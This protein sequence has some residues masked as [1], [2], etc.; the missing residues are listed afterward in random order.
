LQFSL[1]LNKLAPSVYTSFNCLV[2]STPQVTMTINN[3]VSQ[4]TK[5]IEWTFTFSDPMSFTGF[6]YT[7]FLFFNTTDGTNSITGNFTYL[8]TMVDNLNF[9]V[10]MT[11][12]QYVFF[13]NSTFCVVSKAEI[14]ASLQFSAQWFKLA[15]G[16]YGQSNCGIL[17]ACHPYCLIC[18]I[19]PTNCSAC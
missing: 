16:V 9:K 13:G 18:E 3:V 11:A 1:D 19:S 8:Y 15:P 6:V 17:F 5:S 7:D 4:S 10:T 2:W 14:L 12:N